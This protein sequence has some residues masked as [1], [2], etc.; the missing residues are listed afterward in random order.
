MRTERWIGVFVMLSI[1]CAHHVLPA[2][3]DVDAE[4]GGA[5]LLEIANGE[6]HTRGTIAAANRA[7]WIGIALPAHQHGRVELELTYVTP[8]RGARLAFGVFD[9]AERPLPVSESETGRIRSATLADAR[10]TVFVRVYA[11]RHSDAGTYRLAASFTPIVDPPPPPPPVA[12]VAVAPPPKRAPCETFDV[13]DPACA[14]TCPAWG[15]PPDWPACFEVRPCPVKPDI[16]YR[17]CT[18]AQWPKCPDPTNPDLENPNCPRLPTF[19]PVIGRILQVV[20]NGRRREITINVGANSH[21]DTTWNARVLRADG[22]PQPG[23]G[24]KILCMSKRGEVRL[25]VEL[26]VDELAAPND[27]VQLMP[28]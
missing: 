28:P 3:H 10:G 6:A 17:H 25:A 1:S 19:A 8:R 15:A 4:S 26:T 24:A 14:A 11:P 16:R 21:V 18:P 7:D 12:V 22:T 9:P 27:R 2:G 20:V 13:R 5:T 23:G